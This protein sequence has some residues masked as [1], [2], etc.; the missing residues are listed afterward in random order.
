VIGLILFYGTLLLLFN[1]VVGDTTPP[2]EQVR[3]IYAAVMPTAQ[4]ILTTFLVFC[5]LFLVIFCEPPTAWWTGGDRLSPDRRPLIL[6]CILM[7]L[8]IVIL[9]VPPLSAI[10]A[11]ATL[12]WQDMGLVALALL[13]WLPLVRWLWRINLLGRFLAVDIQSHAA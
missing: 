4:T 6:A 7:A 5:G 2:P 1:Q 11:L 12:T 10:F 13:I 3:Q 9:V 8:F